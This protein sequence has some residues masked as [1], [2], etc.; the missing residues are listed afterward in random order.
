MKYMKPLP[1]PTPIEDSSD[2]ESSDVIIVPTPRTEE[3]APLWHPRAP[4]RE[5]SI[6]DDGRRDLSQYSQSDRDPIDFEMD[7][8]S[9]KVHDIVP[10]ANPPHQ[11]GRKSTTTPSLLR[12]EVSV[13]QLSPTPS[14][15]VSSEHPAS[16]RPVPKQP[17]EPEG[18]DFILPSVQA[19][20]SMTPGP[21]DFFD[22]TNIVG[23]LQQGANE[24]AVRTYFNYFDAMTISRRINDTV[25][26]FPSIFYAA[27]TNNDRI[28]RAW[29]ALGGDVNAIHAPSQAPLL[30]FAIV[31]SETIERDTSHIVA[32]L[33]SLGATPLAIPAAFYTPYLR[34]LPDT[35]PEDDGLKDVAAS[36][37]QWLSKD[38]RAKL[39][40]TTHLTN[41]Y[42][43]E[44]ALKTKRPSAR[45][46]QIA[47]RKNAEPLLGLPYFLIGQSLAANRLL[48]K[49]LAHLAVP[50]NKPL[51]LVFAGL[52]GHG[53]TELARRLGYLMNLEL[54]V[55][56]CTI[57]SHEMEL[58]GG[59]H[60]YV[61]ADRGTPLN[62][63]LARN[64]GQRSIVFLDE[65][66]K[67]T[68]EI[69]QALLLP[70]DNG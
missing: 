65:F 69:H 1:E 29:I 25:D 54:E 11:P 40:R 9:P 26:G 18:W 58:F 27:A 4:R 44:R 41:R 32:T 12:Q 2:D 23:A 14:A 31:H 24:Q 55:V 5:P 33:L 39:A 37:M 47:Q 19:P 21:G 64:S 42:N 60:P 22:P 6:A 45:H 36:T 30:A 66:E 52:S 16:E 15:H 61:N 35:G 70:F 20:V 59:R 57:V 49:F 34:E 67:T 53:K 46:W 13:E 63:F 3:E 8:P 28:L 7:N 62:N 56:D 50:G 51:V 38:I 68:R 48:S 10:S 17:E 43:L